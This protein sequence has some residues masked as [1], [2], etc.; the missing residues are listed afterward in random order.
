MTDPKTPAIRNA[1]T[2]IPVR[3]TTNGGFD[4]LL[5]RRAKHLRFAPHRWVFPG[6][7]ID[8]GDYQGAPD[9]VIAATFRAAS[10]E[11]HEECGI[12]IDTEQQY[13]YS[14]WLTPAAEPIRF[15]TWFNLAVV[16]NAQTI[17]IN[18][19]ESDAYGWFSANEALA[20]YANGSIKLMP[21]TY[22]SLLEMAKFE[23][24]VQLLEFVKGRT[25]PEFN[26][27]II[28]QNTRITDVGAKV[29]YQQDVAFE[30]EDLSLQGKRHRLFITEQGYQYINDFA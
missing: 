8:Q 25:P 30:S 27:K 10:R 16:D 5:L 15:R 20:G 24:L 18:E 13:R 3:P 23:Q 17:T 29:L 21:P 22:I 6:G 1:A 19:A 28:T 9:D 4:V 7:A 11:A 2:V 14:F 12:T 26:P